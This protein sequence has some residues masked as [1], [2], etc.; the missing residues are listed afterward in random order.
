MSSALVVV[1]LISSSPGPGSER[2]PSR[3]KD[4]FDINAEF[5][6]TGMSGGLDFPVPQLVKKRKLSAEN[7]ESGENS[8]SSSKPIDLS[9]EEGLPVSK[10]T[11]SLSGNVRSAALSADRQ[12]SDVIEFTSSASVRKSKKRATVNVLDMSD[13]LDLQLPDIFGSTVSSLWQ[14]VV[15]TGSRGALSERTT[16]LL[17]NLKSETAKRV[18]DPSASK[19]RRKDANSAGANAIEDIDDIVSALPEKQVGIKSRG[20]STEVERKEKAADRAAAKAVRELEKEAEKEQRRLSKEQKAQEKQKA[21]DIAEVNKSKTNKKDSVKEMILDMPR[22]LEKTSIGNQVEA[23]LENL[24]VQF[25]YYDEEIDL[26]RSDSV[27]SEYVGNV[28]R[29]RRK[30]GGVYDPELDQFQPL[31]QKRIEKE[32]HILVHLTGT[33][34]AALVARRPD[35]IDVAHISEA[36]MKA[37]L[38]A[39]VHAIKREHKDCIPIYLIEGL[40]ALLRKNKNAKNR[41]YQ[42]AARSAN[43]G[44]STNDIAAA[45]SSQPKPSKRKQPPTTAPEVSFLTQALT[46]NLLLHLQLAHSPAILLHQVSTP[47]Q[48]AH[49]ITVFTTHLSIRP[50]KQLRAHFNEANAGFCMDNGQVQTGLDASDTYLRMLQELPRVTPSMAHGIRDEGWASVREL[51]AGF[52]KEGRLILEDVRKAVN[53]DG[54]VSDRRVGPSVSKRLYRLFFSDDPQELNI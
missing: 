46:S 48:S 14:P 13:D 35:N 2:S 24:E 15:S 11:T 33:E 12:M 49:W 53:R 51:V 54:G 52:R 21:A 29:W 40:H 30:I 9:D 17:A 32:K 42:A 50:Y 8:G 38:D 16:N 7:D 25:T 4:V 36:A 3:L 34:F 26:S 23:Y 5:D 44:I 47:S 22:G 27:R 19:F 41:D 6:F 31:A 37:N 20:K 45:S 1:D 18:G 43:I 39:H 28:I 10:R